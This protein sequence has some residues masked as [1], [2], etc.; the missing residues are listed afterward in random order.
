MMT[1]L[2]A[3]FIQQNADTAPPHSPPSVQ[4]WSP[5]EWAK[6]WDVNAYWRRNNRLQPGAIATRVST[7]F[8]SAAVIFLWTI[9]I[10]LGSERLSAEAVIAS[11]LVRRA[12]RKLPS[13]TLAQR[14][15]RESSL[16]GR[17]VGKK[18]HWLLMLRFF[19]N[20][21]LPTNQWRLSRVGGCADKTTLANVRRLLR[22]MGS[23]VSR[24]NATSNDVECDRRPELELRNP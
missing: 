21:Y 4:A 15:K 19:S 14:R 20:W 1:T 23:F 13:W 6:L 12:H 5:T 11:H 16:V 7:I 24:V 8:T 2:I 9:R 10:A 3:T 18:I 22:W 17:T